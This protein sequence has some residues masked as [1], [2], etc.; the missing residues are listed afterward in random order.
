MG[1][2]GTLTSTEARQGGDLDTGREGWSI[3]MMTDPNFARDPR[4]FFAHLRQGPPPREELRLDGRKPTVY[5]AR[6]ADVEAVLRNPRLFSSQFGEGMGGLGNDRPMIPLQID[7]PEHKKYRVLLDPYLAPRQVARLE[8]DVVGLVNELIDAFV[9]RGS[10]EF[11]ADFAVPLPCTVFLR[12]LGLPLEHLDLFLRIKEGIIRGN[13]QPTLALQHAARVEAGRT[14]YDYF[15]T[16]LD[17]IEDER[18]PGLLLDLLGADVQGERLSRDEIMDICYLFI[19]AGL[20]TVTDSLCCFWT[21]L[22]DHPD[23][24]KLIVDDPTAIP[25]AVEELIRWESP[26][27]GVARVATEDTTLGGCPVHQGES[28]LVMVG[29]AN[30]DPDAIDAAGTVDFTRTTNRHLAFGGGIHRCLGSHLARLELRVAMREWHRRIPDYRVA[31][32]TDLVWTPMLRCVT[33][34]PLVFG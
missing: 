30:T 23:H 18:I 19:I 13:S 22:A 33:D 32:G 7:P 26:V 4:P 3:A 20:D 2:G 10:C 21:F 16:A 8:D 6:H 5:V 1:P 9:D 17:R 34:M 28:L 24:R 14:F 15:D 31:E 11:L 29:S 27:S 12:L 25:G